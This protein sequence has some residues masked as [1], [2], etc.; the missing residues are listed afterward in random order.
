M[1]TRVKSIDMRRVSRVKRDVQSINKKVKESEER[2][3]KEKLNQ[4]V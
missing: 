1:Y 4:S 2:S 3:K